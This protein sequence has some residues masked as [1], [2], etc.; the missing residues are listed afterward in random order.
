MSC[1]KSLLL[2]QNKSKFAENREARERKNMIIHYSYEYLKGHF[3]WLTVD[4]YKYIKGKCYQTKIPIN[5]VL[6]I[7]ET[8]SSGRNI[9]SKANKIKV[10]FP[11]VQ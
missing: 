6:A 11:K 2:R 3:K 8:E 5:L 10:S 7:I 4:M 1:S 9:I